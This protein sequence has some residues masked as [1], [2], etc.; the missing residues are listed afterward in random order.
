[1]SN[2]QYD[3]ILFMGAGEHSMA[4]MADLAGRLFKCFE[5][6]GGHQQPLHRPETNEEK[7]TRMHDELFIEQYVRDICMA[8]TGKE[9][10]IM[11]KEIRIE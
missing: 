6:M 1:M 3:S 5:I 11:D 4:R 9:A 8:L 2:F 10:T 7:R